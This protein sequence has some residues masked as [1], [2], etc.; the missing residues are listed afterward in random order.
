MKHVLKALVLTG[1][2]VAVCGT[3][4]GASHRTPASVQTAAPLPVISR[5]EAAPD[6]TAVSPPPASAMPLQPIS[7][8]EA[9]SVP[10]TAAAPVDSR[11]AALNAMYLAVV[12]AAERAALAGRY[13][14]GYDVPGV[15]CG[16]GCT[17]MFNGQPRSSYDATFFAESA[18]YERNTVAHEAAH[19]YGFLYIPN[20]TTQ[21]WAGEGGWQAQFQAAAQGFVRTYDAE[22]W[23]AC[24]AWKESGFNDPIDQIRGVCTEAA[25][26]IAMAVIS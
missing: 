10:S 24:V 14:F 6:L 9:A 11:Q 3:S 13:T 22:A 15:S 7:R 4:F 8:V 1:L 21:S 17:N 19:A 26:A 23:A 2:A 18:S 5:I 25:A 12:P 16:T 20:Y